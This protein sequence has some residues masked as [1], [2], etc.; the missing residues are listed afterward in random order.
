MFVPGLDLPVPVVTTHVTNWACFINLLICIWAGWF[1]R[2]FG[3]PEHD[4]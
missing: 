3:R 4:G 1:I 2:Y